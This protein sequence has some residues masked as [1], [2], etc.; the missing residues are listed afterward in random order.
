MPPRQ[1]ALKNCVEKNVAALAHSLIS[2]FE[3]RRA[4]GERATE[5]QTKTFVSGAVNLSC[6]LCS[7]GNTLTCR[8]LAEV[9]AR[10]LV[11]PA[12]KM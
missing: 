12:H 11:G 7:H 9:F 3:I 5:K 6:L 8:V 10:Q 1:F 2:S 4:T